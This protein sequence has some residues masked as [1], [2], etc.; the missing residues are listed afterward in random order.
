MIDKS[1][2]IVIEGG[3]GSGKS[4]LI[5]YLKQAIEK[6]DEDVVI[7]REPGGT[8]FTED[9][10]DVFMKHDDLD[11]LTITHLMNAQR[12]HNINTVIQP[13]L[14]Q[15]KFV[16]SDRFTPSTLIYQGYA[17]GDLN[18][19]AESVIDIPQIT[20]LV[21]IDPEVGLQRIKDNNREQNYLDKMPLENHQK[22]NEGYRYLS[23]KYPE[24]YWD[25]VINGDQ[26]LAN[27]KIQC[28][29]IAKQIVK[30]KQI[31]V[32]NQ[33]EKVHPEYGGELTFLEDLNVG[34]KFYVHNGYWDGEIVEVDGDIAYIVKGNPDQPRVIAENTYMWIKKEE[35]ENLQN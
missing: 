11:N 21:D 26:P 4:T 1:K 16:I 2:F 32:G 3:E 25:Y 18:R 20:I 23:N 22:I 24:K 27:I 29:T 17:N 28:E 7:H 9:I 19:V 31:I 34:D 35:K 14:E 8:G 5:H 33:L 10:R 12:Q 15:N 13:A 30:R 6:Y